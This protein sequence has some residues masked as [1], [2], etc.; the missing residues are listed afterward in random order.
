MNVATQ[1]LDEL[2]DVQLVDNTPQQAS[3]A[4]AEI[5]AAVIKYVPPLDWDRSFFA[6]RIK[7][8][9]KEIDGYMDGI[10]QCIKTLKQWQESA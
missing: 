7:F 10:E 4:W 2:R 3:I 6:A 9:E 5:E 8:L 1:L